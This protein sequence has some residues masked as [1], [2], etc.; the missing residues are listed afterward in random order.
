M[1]ANF[2]RTKQLIKGQNQ[3]NFFKFS[4]EIQEMILKFVLVKD[5]K[6]KLTADRSNFQH[7]ASCKTNCGEPPF[8]SSDLQVLR[9]CKNMYHLGRTVFYQHNTF[10][11]AENAMSSR[12]YLAMRCSWDPPKHW[13]SI[14]SMLKHLL[15]YIAW[16]TDLPKLSKA[17]GECVS[18]K[19]LDIVI[20]SVP[21]D[22][23]KAYTS[24][25]FHVGPN[26]LPSVTLSP[27]VAE[28]E[29]AGQD[30]RATD[31]KRAIPILLAAFRVPFKVN[32]K[33]SAPDRAIIS[34]C[35]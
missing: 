25:Q 1:Q 23:E 12:S 8:D 4:E 29:K 16:H 5:R 31:A 9:T 21:R 33:L 19:N 18:L 27:R 20:H 11:L 30:I 22:Y 6:V 2:V 15:I 34:Q 10:M 35:P 32:T 7:L 3:M 24:T 28:L 17:V 26:L 13:P 14:S